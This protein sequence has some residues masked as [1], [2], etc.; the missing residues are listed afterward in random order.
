[1]NRSM[2]CPWLQ[3]RVERN[4]SL[5]TANLLKF[6][7][8]ALVSGNGGEIQWNL[9]SFWLVRM[10]V[11]SLASS[12]RSVRMTRQWRRQSKSSWL[13]RRYRRSN[14]RQLDRCPQS[15]QEIAVM[16]LVEL[17]NVI[18]DYKTDGQK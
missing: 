15:R 14:L 16:A 17:R 9:R 11:P 6:R 5:R 1:M 4:V 3:K 12:R 18:K 7:L 10:A 2:V 8:G 13:R